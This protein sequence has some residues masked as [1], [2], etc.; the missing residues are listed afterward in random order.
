[1]KKILLFIFTLFTF[2][3]ATSQG[4]LQFNNV[5][6]MSFEASS[7]NPDVKTITVPSGQ[8]L[9]ITSATCSHTSN[10]SY[11]DYQFLNFKE[12]TST[13]YTL[14]ATGR[15][16]TAKYVSETFPVWLKA[17]NYDFKFN[18]LQGSGTGTAIMTGI[19]FNIIQ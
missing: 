2:S 16:T 11:N 13:Y 17:G 15:E 6:T 3:F 5:L 10:Q 12:T 7:G 4:N 14:L 8:V 19:Y 18:N 9:K 1:M